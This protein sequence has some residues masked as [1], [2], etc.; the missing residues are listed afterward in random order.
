MEIYV[1]ISY[2][3]IREEPLVNSFLTYFARYEH[4][5]KYAEQVA[6]DHGC[7]LTVSDTESWEEDE[8]GVQRSYYRAGDRMAFNI[9][10]LSSFDGHYS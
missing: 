6:Q 2:E 4:A 8:R 10:R 1:L 3:V 9:D 7:D 5:L